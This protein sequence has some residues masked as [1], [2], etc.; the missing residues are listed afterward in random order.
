[1]K[2]RHLTV[3]LAAPLLGM[4]P[5]QAQASWPTKPVRVIVAGGPGSGTDIVARVFCEALAK[6]FGQPFVVDNKAG[7]NGLIGTDALVKAPK[8]GHVLLFTYAAAHVVNPVL[9]EKVPYDVNKDFA[10]VAQIG[11]GGNLLVVSSQFPARDLKEFIAYVKTKAPNELSYGSWG[12]GSGGHLSM[13]ALN[14]AA[15]LKMQHVPFK[16]TS[17]SNTALIAGHIQAA[18]S[19]T[20]SALP[21]ITGGRLKPLAIS[22][23][24]RVKQLPE[25][26]TMTEQG[27]TFDVSAWYG[28]I[29]PAGTPTAVVNALNREVLR[30]IA[31]PAMAPR[32]DA[33]GFQEMPL[34]TPAQFEEQIQRDLRD[35]GAVVKAGNIKA[36]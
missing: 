3:A 36:E 20:A 13:E 21:Q 1:M 11:T 24:Y 30:L 9:M 18:F 28:L 22:G 14:Q 34:K 33:L 26:R 2:R 15:G 29:A 6:A 8:D 16:S 17:E 4:G 31:D 10:P 25:V 19:A 23:P 32:W 7:A 35:W 27:V 5:V 12:V